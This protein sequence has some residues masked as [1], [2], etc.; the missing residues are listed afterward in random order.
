MS[1]LVPADFQFEMD[2]SQEV[3]GLVMAKEDDNALDDIYPGLRHLNFSGKEGGWWED[4]KKLFGSCWCVI[5]DKSNPRVAWKPRNENDDYFQELKEA[6]ANTPLCKNDHFVKGKP[7][8]SEQAFLNRDIPN[9]V[10]EF[11][12]KHGAGDCN[13]CELTKSICRGGRKL[14]VQ[15]VRHDGD[16]ALQ[17]DEPIAFQVSGTSI[18]VINNLFRKSFR[19]KDGSADISS[20]W[21]QFGSNREKRDDG[22]T[23]YTIT[24]EAGKPLTSEQVTFWREM[25]EDYHLR[26]RHGVTARVVD[27]GTPSSNPVSSSSAPAEEVAEDGSGRLF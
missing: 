12:K 22:G 6:P 14:L 7:E 5:L 20:R 11:L 13:G 19:T 8:Q 27:N 18:G 17:F 21:V 1:N 3:T 24:A 26:P 16:K 4:D 2:S 9:S 25:R 10:Q 23:Y 15:I